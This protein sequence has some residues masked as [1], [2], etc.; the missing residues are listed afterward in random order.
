MQIMVHTLRCGR[1]RGSDIPTLLER[2]RYEAPEKLDSERPSRQTKIKKILYELIRM[3]TKPSEN[4]TTPSSVRKLIYGSLLIILLA[5]ITIFFRL[6]PKFTAFASVTSSSSEM[7]RTATVSAGDLN[8]TIRITGT[9]GA[10]RFQLIQ[11]PQLL[12]SRGQGHTVGN[13][14]TSTTPSSTPTFTPN[15]GSSLAGASN[16]FS[17]RQGATTTPSTPYTPPSTAGSVY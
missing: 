16:R 3:D 14:S 1:S 11:A 6:N 17:D 10:E 2:Y 7:L 9:T 15:S 5:R 8:E 13:V 12:G 4:R